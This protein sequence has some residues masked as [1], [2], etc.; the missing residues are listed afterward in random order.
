MTEHMRTMRSEVVDVTRFTNECRHKNFMLCKQEKS[1]NNFFS[2]NFEAGDVC[3]TTAWGDQGEEISLNEKLG[4]TN[5]TL[6]LGFG[7]RNAT[8]FTPESAAATHNKLRLHK[9]QLKFQHI[10]ILLYFLFKLSD[11]F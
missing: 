11:Y 8:K 3:F 7:V 5:T 4:G 6:Q 1:A 2:S 9:S 10:E